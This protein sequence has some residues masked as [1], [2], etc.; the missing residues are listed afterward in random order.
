M[1]RASTPA[2]GLQTRCVDFQPA[3]RLRLA[4]LR[5]RLHAGGVDVTVLARPQ[6][7]AVLERDGIVIENPF[8]QRRTVAKVPL[9]GELAPAHRY[10]FILVVVRRNH[11][12]ALLPTLAAN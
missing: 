9:I 6:R 10:D 12:S 4:A 7:L 11:V 1:G 2:A 8:N 5:R 3:F